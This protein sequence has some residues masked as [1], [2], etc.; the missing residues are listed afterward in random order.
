MPT[1]TKPLANSSLETAVT[2]AATSG[3]SPSSDAAATSP[4]NTRT[5][6]SGTP[7]ADA[8]LDAS[9]VAAASSPANTMREL[10]SPAT[11]CTQCT[12]QVRGH[13]GT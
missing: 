6:S 9:D 7:T 2:M 12:T 3:S 13:K 10:E 11:R 4:S 5:S 8:T 1:M